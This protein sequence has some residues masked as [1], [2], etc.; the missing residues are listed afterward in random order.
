MLALNQ[1]YGLNNL[2]LIC[3]FPRYTVPKPAP[4][5]QNNKN[6]LADYLIDGK[7]DKKL[8]TNLSKGVK[9]KESSKH[10]TTII[11]Q[12]FFLDCYKKSQNREIWDSF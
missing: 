7:K 3:V 8:I 5:I 9:F 1:G 12:I 10:E 11:S 4:L 2:W 6:I